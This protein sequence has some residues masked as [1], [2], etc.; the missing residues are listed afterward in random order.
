MSN[1]CRALL[2]ASCILATVLLLDMWPFSRTVVL[3]PL[4]W[5]AMHAVNRWRVTMPVVGLIDESAERAGF[6]PV[7]TDPNPDR[8]EPSAKTK[9]APPSTA[10]PEPAVAPAVAGA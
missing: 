5:L 1:F 8:Q 4:A 3:V 7:P 9:P 10:L 6:Y 2:A